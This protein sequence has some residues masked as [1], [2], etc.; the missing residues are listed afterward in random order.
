MSDLYN[1][2]ICISFYINDLRVKRQK[3]EAVDSIDWGKDEY[4]TFLT[5]LKVSCLGGCSPSPS[6][7]F[8]MY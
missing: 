2:S 8:F 1:L 7:V 3:S 5:S 4:L 6:L